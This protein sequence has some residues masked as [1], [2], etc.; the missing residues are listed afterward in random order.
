MATF[1]PEQF[2][3]QGG[4]IST[5]TNNPI[6][7]YQNFLKSN[8]PGAVIQTTPPASNAG[9]GL[10]NFGKSVLGADQNVVQN[11]AQETSSAAQDIQNENNTN[12][13]TI[14]KNLKNSGRIAETGL[15]TAGNAVEA[16]FAPI[17]EALK[18]VINFAADKISDNSTVQKFSNSKAG[19]AIST[20]GGLSEWAAKNPD[21]AKDLS[22]ATNVILSIIGENPANEVADTAVNNTKNTISDLADTAKNVFNKSAESTSEVNPSESIAAKS[23]KRTADLEQAFNDNRISVKNG[24][25]VVTPSDSGQRMIDALKPLEEQGKLKDPTGIGTKAMQNQLDN[26]ATVQNQIETRGNEIRQGLKD[27]DTAAQEKVQADQDA[28]KKMTLDEKASYKA[29]NNGKPDVSENKLTTKQLRAEMDTVK[30]P[31]PV[32]NEPTL[33]KNV[34]SLK[35][36][37]AELYKK[38][39]DHQS[40]SILDLKQNFDDYVKQNYG[41]NFYSKGRNADPF[42]KYV[43]NLRDKFTN[44][45][46]DRLPEGKLPDG[47]SLDTAFKEQ[48]QLINAKD[49]M[50]AK[51]EEEFKNSEKDGTIARWAKNNPEKIRFLRR[52]GYTA[53][54]LGTAFSLAKKEIGKIV[55]GK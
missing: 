9:T 16:I 46:A 34:T 55:S 2:A 48:H 22:A 20:G 11:Q 26:G 37:A 12:D 30:V 38:I 4:K 23:I 44:L 24:K 7:L 3:A 21:K 54:G 47:T 51:F 29:M 50:A 6:T 45:I 43:F 40:E 35:N 49:E 31:D 39:S 10:L 17:S 33:N 13:S 52:A 42:H 8:A 1:T 41:E 25:S 19:N 28:F 5:P 15:R 18:P 32:K 53:I 27:S 36:A 14:K